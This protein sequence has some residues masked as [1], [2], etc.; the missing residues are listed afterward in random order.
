[1]N[2]AG[3][4]GK[5]I[6][7]VLTTG[8]V[9]TSKALGDTA[10]KASELAANDVFQESLGRVMDTNNKAIER[11]GGAGVNL[12]D[13]FVQIADAARP[14]FRNLSTGS[15]TSPRAGRS[16]PRL[17]NKS[18]ELTEKFKTAQERVREFS[19]SAGRSG[20]P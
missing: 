12:A 10:I 17:S 20:T 11:F 6:M 15:R 13:A 18:G 19:H 2:V 9:G 7:D 14:L 8:L 3:K 16:R 4:D 5:T 1:M